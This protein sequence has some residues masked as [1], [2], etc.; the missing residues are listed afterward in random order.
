MPSQGAREG[1]ISNLVVDAVCAGDE[2]FALELF[3]KLT[4]VDHKDGAAR[5]AARAHMDAGKY[6]DARKWAAYLSD[7]EDKEWWFRAI[8][9]ESREKG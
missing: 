2:T 6:D 1:E 4:L 3:S 5:A 8:L 7:P 9:R